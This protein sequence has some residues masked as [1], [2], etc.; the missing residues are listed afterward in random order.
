[1]WRGERLEGNV[2]SNLKKNEDRKKRER[3]GREMR[4]KRTK[5]REKI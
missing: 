1:M 3:K 4:E 5:D 2:L